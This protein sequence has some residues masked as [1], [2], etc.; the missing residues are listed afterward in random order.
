MNKK[1]KVGWF[2]FTCSEDNS[3]IFLELLNEHY[4]EW[5]D[6]I[7][8]VNCKM[9]K[10]KNELRELDVA[11][12]EGA[13]STA[14][15][16]EML[17]KIRTVAKKLVAVG[18]CACTGMPSGHRNLFDEKRKKEIANFLAMYN[19]R[20]KVQPLK[21]FVEVDGEIG[22]CPMREEQF[23]AVLE[24]YLREFGIK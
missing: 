16:E 21:Y 7:D 19:L 18:A 9:L 4:F 17:K 5:K 15:E 22:G 14:H 1:L 10:S 20:E 24:K 11:F 23:I 8:F 12:V 6:L 2:T 3:I 13:I